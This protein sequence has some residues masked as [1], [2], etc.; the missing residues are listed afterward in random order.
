[1][2]VLHRLAALLQHAILVRELEVE[3]E[4]VVRARLRQVARVLARR[5]AALLQLF[6]EP[7]VERKQRQRA[8]LGWWRQQEELVVLR[9][10]GGGD[11]VGRRGRD[12]RRGGGE[13][14]VRGGAR[15][16]TGGSGGSEHRVR[17]RQRRRARELALE[18]DDLL[19]GGTALLAGALL[20]L[21]MAREILRRTLRVA[22][23]AVVVRALVRRAVGRRD[24]EAMAE[25]APRR[26]AIGLVAPLGGGRRRGRR[27]LDHQRTVAVGGRRSG[28]LLLLE[29]R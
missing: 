19:A 28:W 3:G 20:L 23:A 14:E 9:S 29:C 17:D 2:L 27:R 22:A 10:V 7:I 13:R 16:G 5:F 1:M 6:G 15:G 25:G 11:G 26:A 18:A 4:V 24:A 21:G 8:A 12:G